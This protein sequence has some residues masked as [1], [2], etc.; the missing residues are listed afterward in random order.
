MMMMNIYLFIN[1]FIYFISLLFYYLFI[2]SFI[3]SFY[4][5]NSYPAGH[6]MV[7][8]TLY[9]RTV[10]LPIVGS[11][12]GRSVA[13][14]VTFKGTQHNAFEGRA[15][16]GGFNLEMACAILTQWLICIPFF[17]SCLQRHLLQTKRWGWEETKGEAVTGGDEREK[18]WGRQVKSP[19]IH[20][21]LQAS[22]HRTTLRE[23]TSNNGLK[24]TSY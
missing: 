3:Y 1:L 9:T 11:G 17:L 19:P 21:P 14:H 7:K 15:S 13:F 8:Y 22:S 10:T 23:N 6:L 5:C 16:G 20:P 12:G 4:L 24:N 2:Y 18:E